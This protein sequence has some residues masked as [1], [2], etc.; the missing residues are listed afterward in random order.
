M[1]VLD[2]QRGNQKAD[3]FH[4]AL[5]GKTELHG[6]KRVQ[7]SDKHMTTVTKV[8]FIPRGPGR[9]K[10]Y[11]RRVKPVRRQPPLMSDR[12]NN[13]LDGVSRAVRGINIPRNSPT[14]A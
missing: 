14:V 4:I 11:R 8:D 7:R 12:R 13:L 6:Q 3:L 1:G 9:D 2:T 10:G 5:P